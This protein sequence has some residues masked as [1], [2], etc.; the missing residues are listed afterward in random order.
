MSSSGSSN[1]ASDTTST[2]LAAAT[3]SDTT[4]TNTTAS[5]G[6]TPLQLQAP[7]QPG[8]SACGLRM[9]PPYRLSSVMDA[10]QQDRAVSFSG[11]LKF[12]PSL[13]LKAIMLI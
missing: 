8:P 5:T 13:T 1:T 6:A 4:S 2:N 7:Q 11:H 12:N 10:L 3:A 9:G